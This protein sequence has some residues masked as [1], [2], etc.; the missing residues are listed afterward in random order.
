MNQIEFLRTFCNA[1]AVVVDGVL[2]D[3]GRGL[4]YNRE[5]FNLIIA[6]A[7][8]GEIKEIYISHKYRFVR[9]GYE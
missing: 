6:T 4:N 8:R 1:K 5:N 7:M 3:I 2:T 9:F